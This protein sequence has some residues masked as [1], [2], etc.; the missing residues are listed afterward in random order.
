MP[1]VR[2]LFL[3]TADEV[4]EAVRTQRAGLGMTQT[5]VAEQAGVTRQFVGA[6]ERGHP[7]AELGK[8]LKVLKA[9]GV[10]ALAQPAPPPSTVDIHNFDIKAHLARYAAGQ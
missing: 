8:V 6:V 9:V 7:T 5:Q 4:A 2:R 10:L 1:D 3:T